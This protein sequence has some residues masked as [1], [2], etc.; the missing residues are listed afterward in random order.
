M[1]NPFSFS[2]WS[3]ALGG[4]HLMTAGPARSAGAQN[5]SEGKEKSGKVLAL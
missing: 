3:F 1:A 4:Q 2:L 5:L